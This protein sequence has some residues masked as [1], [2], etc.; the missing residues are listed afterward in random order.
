MT[1]LWPHFVR[2]DF[3]YTFPLFIVAMFFIVKHKKVTHFW[4]RYL[5]KHYQNQLL[6]T[7]SI[8]QS[9]LWSKLVAC[10]FLVCGFCAL[11][12][13]SW[14][15]QEVLAQ[16]QVAPL[17]IVMDLSPQMNFR[18]QSIQKESS[19]TLAKRKIQDILDARGKEPTGLI[20]YSGTAHTVVPLTNDSKTIQNMLS[21]IETSIMPVQGTNAALGILSGLQALAKENDSLNHPEFVKG[22]ILLMTTGID[23]AQI[24]QIQT[25]L[26]AY[27]KV[28][29]SILGIN[30]VQNSSNEKNL[31]TLAQ[32]HHG[33]YQAM[34]L[35]DQDL[36]NLK[37]DQQT[38][39][40]QTESQVKQ[41]KDQ[42]YWFLLPMILLALLLLAR[43]SWLFCLPFV[44]V[45]SAPFKTEASIW[46]SLLYNTN[47]QAQHHIQNGNYAEGL[48]KIEDPNWQAYANYQ[49]EDYKQAEAMYKNQLETKPKNEIT[50]EEIYNYGNALAKQQKYQEALKAWDEALVLRPDFPE[51][52]TNKKLVKDLLKQQEEQKQQQNQ[53]NKEQEQ[54]QDQQNEKNNEQQNQGDDSKN[55]E[56]KQNDSKSGKSQSDQNQDQQS[57]QNNNEQNQNEPNQSQNSNSDDNSTDQDKEQPD[58]SASEQSQEQSHQQND[59]KQN[60]AQ[61][62]SASTEDEKKHNEKDEQQQALEQALADQKAQ[63]AAKEETQNAPATQAENE[64]T[65]TE[66]NQQEKAAYLQ[67]LLDS[68]PDKPENSSNL[69]RNK[70]Y[71]E[72]QTQQGNPK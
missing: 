11:L 46:E 32:Q 40:I 38:I 15:E 4:Q 71:Y 47:Q 6:N 45:F 33:I 18:D 29:L 49:L 36:N 52:I 26:K 37:L 21:S 25:E 53:Q 44:F 7:Q 54:K 27:P 65:E 60:P 16:D 8:Q 9:Y 20:V 56:S 30:L 48:E 43:R 67:Q 35:T 12:G 58:Q 57:E 3:I 50:A 39:N 55:N 10:L 41:F 51:A 70:F 14:T 23:S 42:G 19:L 13:P 1:F 5:P 72:Y 63:E 22:S 61:S 64:P 59:D 24:K 66:R 28:H 34:T 31:H 17:S 69:L 68:V 2:P 62:E